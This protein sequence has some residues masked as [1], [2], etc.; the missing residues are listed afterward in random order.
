MKDWK[1]ILEG[2]SSN[3]NIDQ[4]ENVAKYEVQTENN[5]IALTNPRELQ[6]PP[7]DY[8]EDPELQRILVEQ[9]NLMNV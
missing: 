9:K 5:I 2:N 8:V 4:W 6:K 7:F 3:N 1:I